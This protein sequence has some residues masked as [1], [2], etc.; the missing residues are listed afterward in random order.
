ML[1]VFDLDETLIRGDSSQLFT[2]FL[3][4]R[5]IDTTPDTENRDRAFMAAYRAGE[6]DLEDYMTFSLAPLKGWGRTE[7][8]A[9]VAE[10][11]TEVI[12]PRALPTGIERVAWHKD[13]GHDV[14]II[15]A[16]GDHLVSPIARHLGIDQGIGVEV[17]WHNDT[18]AGSI[19]RRRPFREGKIRALKQWLA[20][21][22][23][24][25]ER[26]WFYSDSHNDLPLLNYV[27]HPV[28]VNPDPSLLAYA[29]E[30]DWP[31][32]IDNPGQG[33]EL[34]SVPD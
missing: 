26:L 20:S 5:G 28:A 8:S 1:A 14:L 16:T 33:T 22:P 3:R 27:D 9:L 29:R 6:L 11:V 13:Q 15:S 24:V 34:N 31:V 10:F 32:Y 18:L 2:R 25:P 19:G 23:T 17:E 4:N 7:L 21:R 12:E 30:R